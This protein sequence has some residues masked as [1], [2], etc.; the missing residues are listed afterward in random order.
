MYSLNMPCT[1]I[2]FQAWFSQLMFVG[3]SAEARLI[4]FTIASVH[5]T[6][7]YSWWRK[8]GSFSVSWSLEEFSWCWPFFLQWLAKALGYFRGF[9]FLS[10]WIPGS[11]HVYDGSKMEEVDGL[12]ETSMAISLRFTCCWVESSPLSQLT[13]KEAEK[14]SLAA[15]H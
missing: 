4:V 9:Y 12:E 15:F 13:V 8:Q 10:S 6:P 7:W 3:N 2:C 14:W 11:V 1:F 5:T